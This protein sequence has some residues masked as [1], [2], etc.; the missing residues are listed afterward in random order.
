MVSVESM[1]LVKLNVLHPP[2]PTAE[3]CC[4][5]TGWRSKSSPSGAHLA[6]EVIILVDAARVDGDAGLAH[7]SSSAA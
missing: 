1:L 6:M 4:G 5:D 2:T 3:T 7:G